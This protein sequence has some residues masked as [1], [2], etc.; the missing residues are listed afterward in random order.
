MI[1]FVCH[2]CSAHKDEVTKGLAYLSF[3][4]SLTAPFPFHPFP[5]YNPLF[6][7]PSLS[8]VATRPPSCGSGMPWPHPPVSPGPILVREGGREGRREGDAPEEK[9]LSSPTYFIS[10]PYCSVPSLPPSLPPP[11]PP[12]LSRRRPST[13]LSHSTSAR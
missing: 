6:P 7:F 8:M 13:H 1:V 5:D 11:L 12:S 4:L 3:F 9:S 10:Q 2:V